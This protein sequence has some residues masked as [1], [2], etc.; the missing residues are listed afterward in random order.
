[1]LYPDHAKLN[2]FPVGIYVHHFHHDVLMDGYDFCGVGDEPFGHLG[3]MYKA[4]LLDTYIDEST[5]ICDIA[6]D[7]RKNHSFAEIGYGAYVLVKFKYFDGFTRVT[8]R[9]VEL[10]QDVL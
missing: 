7:A 3:E 6:Y 8:P 9:F 2:P 1:M 5:E 4:I 10:L